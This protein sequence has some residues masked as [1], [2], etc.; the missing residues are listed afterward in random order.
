[1]RRLGATRA[2]A[3]LA[4]VVA[5]GAVWNA[6]GAFF[7]PGTHL[8][9][10][11]TVGVKGILALGECLVILGGGID[12]SLGAVLALSAMVFSGLMIEGDTPF[13]VAAPASVAT[14]A[15]IGLLNG[16]LVARARVQPF[17]A[18]LATM[19]IARG[20]A[21]YVPELA[22]K[23]ASSKFLPRDPA[24]PPSWQ[25][26]QSRILF[27]LPIS[28]LFFVLI[29]AALVFSVRRTTFGRHLRAIGGNHEAARLSG[30]AVSRVQIGSYAL[31]SALAGF[32]AICWV[33]RDVQGSPGAGQM[34]E[35]DAIAAVVIGGCSLGGG[36]GGP[37]LAAIGVLTLGYIEKVL[38]L[39]GVP[40]HWRLVIQGA[41]I[42]LAVGLQGRRP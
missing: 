2:L 5:L 32:A 16:L 37:G 33:A 22:G 31:C 15:A 18:T 39:N 19:V 29:A 21:R 26:L 34:Y 17:L 20:L 25:W 12:L 8:G 10:L 7:A 42:V 27:D 6:D 28:G 30:V 9:L 1:M 23:P 4:S 11:D 14:A 3:A 38:S 24:G 13:W 41:I 40:D 35:L 36:R